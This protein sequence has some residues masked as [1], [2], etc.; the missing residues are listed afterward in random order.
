MLR[1]LLGVD[2][3][4]LL[5]DRKLRNHFEHYDHRIEE[6]AKESPSAVY[7]DLIMNPHESMWGGNPDDKFLGKKSCN[8]N[9]AYNSSTK[10][11]TFRGESV[12]LGALL[13]A[14]DDILNKCR[15]FVLT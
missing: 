13:S 5:S 8:R 14:L 2:N 3:K 15:P 1:T 6:W 4:N 12:D 10:T 7:R 9:R 11:V